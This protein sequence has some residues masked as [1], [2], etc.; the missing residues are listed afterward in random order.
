MLCG[1][2]GVRVC[3]AAVV[4][5]DEELQDVVETGMNLDVWLV[6]LHRHGAVGE[7][8]QFIAACIGRE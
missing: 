1:V 2:W 8:H 6:G 4:L 5:N 7:F 3:Q